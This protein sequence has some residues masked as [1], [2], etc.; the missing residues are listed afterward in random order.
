MCGIWDTLRL[1]QL[2][3][4]ETHPLLLSNCTVSS[5]S[6]I[7]LNQETCSLLL[8]NC[9]GPQTAS[10][11]QTAVLSSAHF[12]ICSSL[13]SGLS[14][15]QIP[16]IKSRIFQ[17]LSNVIT[18]Q[19]LRHLQAMYDSEDSRK[20]TVALRLLKWAVSVFSQTLNLWL[21]KIMMFESLF[22]QIK[23]KHLPHVQALFDKG[24][25][26][27]AITVLIRV[28]SALDRAFSKYGWSEYPMS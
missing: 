3:H 4:Q 16:A 18:E 2:S 11:N 7:L 19:H 15:L 8:L 22:E 6:R 27:K 28:R 23:N 9:T 20:R 13:M 10:S 26:L 25:C 1:T 24:Q 21:T 17:D 12:I 14:Q 5:S